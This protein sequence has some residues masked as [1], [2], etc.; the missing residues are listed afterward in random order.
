[1]GQ[2]DV[3]KWLVNER[4]KG[5]HKYKTIKEVQKGLKDQGATNGTI[6]GVGSDLWK[7]TACNFLEFRGKGLWDHKKLFRVKG[8]YVK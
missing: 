3:F 7:L 4:I 8:E 5:N 6:K 2:H 1:M